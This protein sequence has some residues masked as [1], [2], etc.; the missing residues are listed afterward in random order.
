MFGQ[1]LKDIRKL[2]DYTQ[3]DVALKLASKSPEFS[4][5]D[6]VTISRWERGIT[7][8][9]NAKAIRVLRCLTKDLTPYLKYLSESAEVSSERLNDFI[10][11]HYHS[12][13]LQ[14]AFAAYGLGMPPEEEVIEQDVAFKQV[15]DPILEKIRDF[16]SKFNRERL[17]LL[18]LDL[19]LY[20]EER[21]LRGVRF[22]HPS[23][24]EHTLGH[25]ISFF[26]N[27]EELENQLKTNGCDIDF[28]K[29][30]RYRENVP[31]A[32]FVTSR[33][34]TSGALFRHNWIQQMRF[35]ATHSNITHYYTSIVIG[36][37]VPFLTDVGFEIVATKK[38]LEKGGIK[39]GRRY[40]ERCIMKIDTSVLLSSKESLS[41]GKIAFSD[42]N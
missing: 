37:M 9:S 28:K 38:R 5:I 10:S 11:E 20:Q 16:H 22:F 25:S 31:Q 1:F 3:K 40:Y 27:Y 41:L 12:K 29:S 17:D 34:I 26:F 6:L 8:P 7:S 4:Q 35:L 21:K 32:M 2:N 14:S 30:A 18:D 33:I 15:N 36:S 19:Y 13:V 42:I 23:N 39:I 24:P